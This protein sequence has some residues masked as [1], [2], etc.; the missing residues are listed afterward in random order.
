VSLSDTRTAIK[1][2][3][4]GVD[5]VTGYLKR[6]SPS[7]PGDAWPLW[8]GAGRDAARLFE[9]VWAIGVVLPTDEVAANDWID[10][11]ID[12]LLD[13]LRSVAYVD[14]YVPANFGSDASPVNGLLITGNIE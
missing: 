10:A 1:A 8:R 6:P 7:K 5:G 4:D 14:A 13:G 2:A 11:H 12:G 9:N 3:L